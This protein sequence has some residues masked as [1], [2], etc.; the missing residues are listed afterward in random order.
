MKK[1]RYAL[2][3]WVAWQFTKRYAR[4]KLPVPRD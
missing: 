2:F 3:G 1:L 4:R